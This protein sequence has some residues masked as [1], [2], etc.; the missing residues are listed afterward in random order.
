MPQSVL[1]A[2]NNSA[3][4]TAL[5]ILRQVSS[6]LFL[7]HLK[8]QLVTLHAVAL[9]SI[10]VHVQ[11]A[12]HAPLAGLAHPPHG[13]RQVIECAPAPAIPAPATSLS[14]QLAFEAQRHLHINSTAACWVQQRAIHNDVSL[15]C[16]QH[17]QAS[18][19]MEG[20]LA[21]VQLT[22]DARDACL[23]QG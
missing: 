1:R 9:M 10:Q 5:G 15:P 18:D 19:D 20:F 4:H 13:Q 2:R 22:H 3:I 14:T 12:L 11:H 7:P 17:Q 23:L 21:Q 8:V 6:S 16:E